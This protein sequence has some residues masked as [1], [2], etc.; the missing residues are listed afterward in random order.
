MFLKLLSWLGTPNFSLSIFFDFSGIRLL[1]IELIIYQT[2][3]SI[4]LQLSG[5]RNGLRYF[6]R[7]AFLS[8]LFNAILLTAASF[9]QLLLLTITPLSLLTIS[10]TEPLLKAIT[11]VPHAIA[12]NITIPKGSSHSIGKSNAFACPRYLFFSI[13]F[14]APR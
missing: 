3:L 11:G 4:L 14:S 5:R 6:S 1:T 13:S 12:S 9:P 8:M 10:L 2:G 7:Q